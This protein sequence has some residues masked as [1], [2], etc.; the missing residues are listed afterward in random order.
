MNFK[1]ANEFYFIFKRQ[2]IKCNVYTDCS[3]LSH[4]CFIVLYSKARTRR[5]MV[6][7]SHHI[8]SP[9][10]ALHRCSFC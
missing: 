5:V 9:L 10:L 6:V 2:N 3:V 7:V 1:T 4:N 8:H